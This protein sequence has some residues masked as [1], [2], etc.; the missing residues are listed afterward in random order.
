MTLLSRHTHTV[1]SLLSTVPSSSEVR[2]LPS[3][4]CPACMCVHVAASLNDVAPDDYL[5][6]SVSD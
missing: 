4:Y 3:I 2:E 5:H 1:A 6:Q